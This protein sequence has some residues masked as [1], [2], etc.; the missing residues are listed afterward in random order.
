MNKCAKWFSFFTTKIQPFLD[1]KTFFV[2]YCGASVILGCFAIPTFNILFSLAAFLLLTFYILFSSGKY[3]LIIISFL[4]GSYFVLSNLGGSLS[5][6][7]LLFIVYIFK[8]LLSCLIDH[9][10]LAPF[11]SIFFAF[12]LFAFYDFVVAFLHLAIISLPSQV[13]FLFYIF[14]P[15]AAFADT[16]SMKKLEI[17]LLTMGISLLFHDLV[18]I[19]FLAIPQIKLNVFLVNFGAE[20]GAQRADAYILFQSRFSGLFRDSNE[21]SLHIAIPC[22]SYILLM[23]PR[24]YSKLP[25]LI[26]VPCILFGF[27]SGSKSFI[28]VFCLFVVMFMVVL[29][30]RFGISILAGICCVLG[31]VIAVLYFYNIDI[32][33]SVFGRFFAGNGDFL[34]NITT[35]RSDIWNL[36]VNNLFLNPGHLLFGY[37]AKA[38]YQ[39]LYLGEE[40]HNFYINLLFD[41]GIFGTLLYV[42]YFF[43]LFKTAHIKSN[44]LFATFISW[45]PLVL[46][47]VFAFG[48][49]L[50]GSII[51]HFFALIQV[52]TLSQEGELP[53]YKNEKNDIASMSVV[54]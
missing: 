45:S 38:S 26:F 35:G 30:H 47:L 31:L 20:T 9:K 50:T 15:F 49:T 14:F 40:P 52:L 48:L 24:K 27:L 17:I 33:D 53:K 34:E 16:R 43:L 22:F 41:F 54:I 6:H 39:I 37:G 19:P 7:S 44:S 28:L 11:F 36:Y 2:I 10:N 46:F 21:F 1:R 32:I 51:P 42:I 13:S 18:S 12:C 23:V 5:F 25:L 4:L 29:V 3:N 8:S